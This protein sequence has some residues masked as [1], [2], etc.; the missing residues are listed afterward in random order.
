MG[1]IKLEIK[2]KDDE[3]YAHSLIRDFLN[4]NY[5]D[6]KF[7]EEILIITGEIASNLLKHAEEGGI[8]NIEGDNEKIE[9]ISENN[10]PSMLKEKD[11]EDGFTSKDSLGIGLGAVKRLSDHIEISSEE[12]LKIKIEKY[13]KRE[14]PKLESAVLSYPYYG[15]A[16]LN[17]DGYCI[18]RKRNE[19]LIVFLDALGHGPNA[20]K[21]KEKILKYINENYVFLKDF[22]DFFYSLHKKMRGEIGAAIGMAKLFKEKEMVSMEYIGLGNIETRLFYDGKTIYFLSKD[23]ILG[24]GMPNVKIQ[25]ERFKKGLLLMW[26]DGLSRGLKYEGGD[27]SATEIAKELMNKYYKKIDD[28]T[29]L[30]A[31]IDV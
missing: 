15:K 4:K 16:E 29:I 12:K 10:K 8:I 20:Y 14:F 17:G 11:F 22:L 26:T 3:I 7:K 2:K 1:K 24:E 19:I 23:G 31:R 27:K 18:L 9:I 28:A 13:L 21:M 25:K 30:V 6:G 5:E